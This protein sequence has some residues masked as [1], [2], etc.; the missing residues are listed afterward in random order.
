MKFSHTVTGAY[1]ND[2]EGLWHIK[3]LDADGVEFED[4][5]NLLYNGSGILK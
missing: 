4:T 1:W 3:V 5:C 2:D